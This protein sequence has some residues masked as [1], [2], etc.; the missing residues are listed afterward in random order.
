MGGAMWTHSGNRDCSGRGKCFWNKKEGNHCRCDAGYKRH[1]IGKSSFCC[2]DAEIDSNMCGAL[3]TKSASSGGA[4]DAASTKRTFMFGYMKGVNDSKS[5]G[6]SSQFGESEEE[7]RPSEFHLQMRS[8]MLA[9]DYNMQGAKEE[10][11]G[12]NNLAEW[13][14]SSQ[15]KQLH[16]VV[17]R[18]FTPINIPGPLDSLCGKV[19]FGQK[20]RRAKVC[21]DGPKK[22]WVCTS[23]ADCGLD[24]SWAFEQLH[25]RPPRAEERRSGD[26][27]RKAPKRKVEKL[28]SKF[29][30]MGLGKKHPTEAVVKGR[31][32]PEPTKNSAKGCKF[33]SIRTCKEADL[34]EIAALIL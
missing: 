14:C 17:S 27:Y 12:K 25:G 22:N 1:D 8:K 4:T 11:P 23:D 5:S 18:Y 34:D 26:V 16:C 29:G 31:C 2:T 30:G 19:L 20:D 10:A 33:A 21:R 24:F 6:Q 13:F 9:N 15:K 3:K 7:S 32:A 28:L